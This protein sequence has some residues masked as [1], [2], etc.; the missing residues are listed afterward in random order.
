MLKKI[1]DLAQMNQQLFAKKLEKQ[2]VQLFASN[3]F[4]G[5]LVVFISWG[6]YFAYLWP[7]ILY[8]TSDGL[9]AGWVGVWGDWAA[10]ITYANV[11]ALRP[12]EQWF[13]NHPLY[14]HS[15]FTYPFAAD[16]I[17][18]LLM[19]AGASLINAFVWPSIL[20][21]IFFLSA[22]YTFYFQLFKK[23]SRALVG[24][25]LFLLN[26]GWGVWWFIKD[27]LNNPSAETLL[28]SP[29]QY[30]HVTDSY[31]EWISIIT[32]EMIPQRSFLLGFPLAV[33]IVWQANKWRKVHF[34]KVKWWR[35]TLLGLLT[36][37]LT[38]IHSHS[39]LALF[40]IL[41]TLAIY[42]WRQW[43]YWLLLAISTL[44][45]A[46]PILYTLHRSLDTSFFLFMPG[47]FANSQAHGINWF[48]FWWL[49]YGLFLPL[50]LLGTW[51][52]K[53]YRQPLVVAGWILF[54]AVNLIQF[55]P[56]IWD[57]TKILTWSHLLLV[58]PVWYI[59][60]QL[61]LRRRIFK[62]LAIGLFLLLTISSWLDVWRFT[63]VDR[64]SYQMWSHE[65]LALAQ[66]LNE[67][68]NSGDR[69]LTGQNHNSWVLAHTHTQVLMAFPGWLWTYGITDP[70]L[71]DDM[72]TMFLGDDAA[73]ELLRQYQIKWVVIG[74]PERVD[75][76][77]NEEWY[78][79][80][81]PLALQG[82]EY[83]VYRIE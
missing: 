33:L 30:T 36:G 40:F 53:L 42:S 32:S 59:L 72:M 3:Y 80:N 13:A 75:H 43:R 28:Y 60:H 9:Q 41:A 55:Q 50:A 37:S 27:W 47:W 82:T 34:S 46:G 74:A 15:A 76:Q 83:N 5:L 73:L 1:G 49:N 79:A 39:F 21:S 61:W 67:L 69:V 31:I 65:D 45:V 11:F 70:Q 29:R 62:G 71:S 51:W 63:R 66:S 2:L 17:S 4:A 58:W 23:A 25:S 8:F 77:A 14:I 57:N 48:Y 26:G 78:A 22:V 56:H 38:I 81:F 64:N 12:I 10:H 35:V 18:G 6:M 54:T 7:Q 68:S 24:L 19:R 44:V 16:A 20:A 52:G